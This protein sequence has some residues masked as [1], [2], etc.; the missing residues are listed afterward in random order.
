MTFK[1]WSI[2]TYKG[3]SDKFIEDK[4]AE[5]T[6]IDEIVKELE[7]YDKGYHFRI[8]KKNQYI[9]FGDLDHYDK[10]F[11]TFIE[12]LQIFLKEIYEL[13][14]VVEEIKYTDNPSKPGSFHYSIPKWNASTEKLWQIHN[15]FL[16]RYKNEL[17]NNNGNCI[18]TSIY[19]EH[20]FRCP[21]QK[22]GYSGDQSKHII[23]CGTME[24]FIPEYIPLDS[25]DINEINPK[26]SKI[27]K[28]LNKVLCDTEC[29][30]SNNLTHIK[31]LLEILSIERCNDYNGW[32]EVGIALFNTDKKNINLWKGWSKKSEKYN[33]EYCDIKWKSFKTQDKCLTMSSLHFWAKTDNPDKYHEFR[34]KECLIDFIR[35]HDDDLSSIDADSIQIGNTIKDKNRCIGRISSNYC[36]INKMDHENPHNQIEIYN[37]Y[38]GILTC[39]HGSCVGKMYKDSIFN[40]DSSINQQLFGNNKPIIIIANKYKQINNFGNIVDDKIDESEIEMVDNYKIFENEEY[41]KLVMESLENTPVTIAKVIWHLAN[42]RFR[43]THNKVWYIF[44]NNRWIVNDTEI[45]YYISNILPDTYKKVIKFYRD[46]CKKEKNEYEIKKL[47][48]KIKLISELEKSLKKTNSINNILTEAEF[49]FNR[50]DEDFEN[51][52]DKNQYLLGFSNGVY[53]LQDFTFRPGKKEDYITMSTCY[54]YKENYSDKIVELTKFL[55]DIQPNKLERDYMLTAFSLSLIGSNTQELLHILSGSGRNGKSKL[56]ELLSLS[57][58]DYYEPINA[59]LLTKEQP[60]TNIPRPELLVLKNKRIVVASEP[61]NKNQTLNAAFIKLLTGNDKITARTLYNDK[62]ITFI[63][64][65]NLHLLCNDI[66]NF[67][68]NDDAIWSRCRCIEFPIKFVETP[69][70]EWQKKIDHNIKDKLFLWKEDIMLLLI[71][72]YREYKQVG[73]ITTKNIMRFTKQTKDDNDIYKVYLNERTKASD[74]HIHT[75][76]LYDDFKHWFCI[77]NPKTKIPSNKEF[78]KELRH[79]YEVFDNVRVDG[80]NTTGIK[81]LQIKEI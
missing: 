15:K 64:N 26:T 80:K 30:N 2:D 48:L 7:T 25:I 22:K 36:H 54:E 75:S 53:D 71:E 18:D 32:L 70:T 5:F 58:G 50:N 68:K 37:N 13:E 35:K 3:K 78:V 77:N 57:F 44:K 29:K 60:S 67:D 51:K 11:E 40:V 76:T 46:I 17:S 20:W 24:D 19:S 49:I 9:F 39:T 14:F 81:N 4:Y 65:F 55:E 59:T 66:P 61:E 63:P 47:K 1:L 72:K 79:H 45:R 69:Q 56:A 12:L 27:K 52:L 28:Q 38:G 33:E 62:I 42:D 31:M 21:N 34:N 10:P 23:K 74:K 73:L 8:H 43:C 16:N 41:N 6:T